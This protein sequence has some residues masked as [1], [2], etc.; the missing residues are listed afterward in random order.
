MQIINFNSKFINRQIVNALVITYI[1]INFIYFSK[2]FREIYKFK[3]FHR[4]H[5][6]TTKKMG[7]LQKRNIQV[8]DVKI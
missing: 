6:Q 1:K 3:L 4:T 7:L 8:L 2:L 5:T